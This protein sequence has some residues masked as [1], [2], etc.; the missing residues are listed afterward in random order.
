MELLNTALPALGQAFFL[1]L[2]PAQLGFLFIG[3]VLGLWVGIVPGIGA[4]AWLSLLLPFIYG[5]D[6]VSGL[7]LM[8]GLL[9][10]NPTSDTFSSVLLGIPGGA[11]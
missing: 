5:L 7:A 9:A 2:Q 10:T 4:I 3:V 6:P 1:L 8:T 11:S